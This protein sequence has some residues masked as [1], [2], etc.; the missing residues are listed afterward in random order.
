MIL[1]RFCSEA[2][3][4]AF[5]KGEKLENTKVHGVER[6]FNATTSV[7]FCFFEENPEDA[8]HWLSGIVDLDY[9]IT[10]E[11]EPKYLKV[12]KGRYK[13]W[14]T[15]SVHYRKEYCCT[16]YDNSKF[17]LIDATTKY[18]TYAPNASDLKVLI[19]FLFI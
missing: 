2:E 12:S 18:R 9:C 17:R 1:H 14:R 16:H 3:Y 6:G 15:Q 11:V 7:G 10:V 5:V 8:K 4:N 13:N 19:P